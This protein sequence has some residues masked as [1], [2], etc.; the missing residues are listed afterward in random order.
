MT[1]T[2]ILSA[3][4]NSTRLAALH[5]DKVAVTAVA[6]DGAV[7]TVT[8][9]E[10]EQWANRLGRLLA[11]SGLT[12]SDR[13]CVALP[14]SALYVAVCM[15]AWKVG[16]CVVPLRAELP[17]PERTT[18]LEL[19]DPV[20]VVSEWDLAD[21]RNLTPRDLLDADVLSA[22]PLPDV[23]PWPGKAICSGG[24]TGRPKLIVDPN[25]WGGDPAEIAEV[26]TLKAMGVRPGQVQL[27]SS[28]LYH[29]S[30]FTLLFVGLSLDH[31]IVLMERFD[32]AQW[33][34]LVERHRVTFAYLAPTMMQR[35]VRVP[36]VDSRD[37][38]SLDA[39][40]H[41]AAPCP[42]WLK[43]RW[44]E[45]LGP[46][47]VREVYGSTEAIGSTGI[48]GDEWLAH[49]GSVGR[50]L[51]CELCIL[52]EAGDE[53]PAGAIGEVFV[54]PL[55]ERRSFEYIGSEPPKSAAGGWSSVGDL[56]WVDEDGYLF[57][58]DRRVDMIVTGGANVYPAEVEQVLSAHP[59]VADCAVVGPPDDEWGRRVHAVIE[60]VDPATTPTAKE[61]DALCR[62]ALASYK[63]PKS[64]TFLPELPRN[65]AGKLRR[66]DLQ[67]AVAAE[68]ASDR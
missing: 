53:V 36:D 4:A 42:D 23:M 10:L 21:R 14:P 48:V 19:C 13:V 57:L 34:D 58:A 16:A 29:N 44:I 11:A 66:S 67:A 26:P 9:L 49:P 27:V 60:P 68:L 1:A 51:D 17:G 45:L 35:I 38:S 28:A 59:G 54:R 46:E 15:G 50:P 31:S 39:L 43:R 33:L 41:A 30:A 18:L 62:A 8:R 56:G 40:Y 20:V 5:P 55:G 64:Y 61:L 12:S 47:R 65:E 25:P 7:R 37:L 6:A 63:V 22:D 32:A 3:G 24:S 52:D 2:T